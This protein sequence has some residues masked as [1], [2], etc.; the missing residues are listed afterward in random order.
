MTSRLKYLY[1]PKM[2]A[3]IIS[4]PSVLVPTIIVNALRTLVYV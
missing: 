2:Q 3:P 1:I 4:V